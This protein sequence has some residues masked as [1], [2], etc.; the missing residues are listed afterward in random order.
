MS[1]KILNTFIFCLFPIISTFGFSISESRQIEA[2]RIIGFIVNCRFDSALALS[3]SMI[4]SQS[5]EPMGYVLKLM[6][7]GLRDLDYD[8]V[9]DDSMFEQTYRKTINVLKN[10]KGEKS[11]DSYF[12]TMRGFA[13]AS[14]ATFHLRKEKYFS[15]MSTGLDAI[16]DLKKAKEMDPENHDA[17]FFLGLYEYAKSELR[18]KL[19][20][21]LFWY[22][23][24]KAEGIRKLESA[25]RK[26]KIVADAAKMALIDIYTE[27][28]RFTE[29]I[30]VINSLLSEY[31]SS[32]FVLWSKARYYQSLGKNLQAADVYDRLSQSYELNSS[33]RH[34]AFVTRMHQL[35]HL[36]K[37]GDIPKIRRATVHISN[38]LCSD[39][40]KSDLCKRVK[41]LQKDLSKDALH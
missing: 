15:A 26:G 4:E 2:S 16:K 7:V 9:I 18:K 29:S 39:E 37:L 31:P 10:H 38:N 8:M 41:K 40:Q 5:D 32:R 35:D 14:Y 3:N 28:K 34:N 20:M 23:G 33:G 19:W 25:A 11:P 30:E 24:D 21:V 22:P 36:E 6:T 13:N 17:D 1:Q 27:E 12:L